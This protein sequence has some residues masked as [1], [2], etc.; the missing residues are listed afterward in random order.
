MIDL[1]N[2][3]SSTVQGEKRDTTVNTTID[4]KESVDAEETNEDL[5]GF[6]KISARCTLHCKL[7]NDL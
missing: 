7:E 5:Q 6:V 1:G 3:E 4:I 2:K